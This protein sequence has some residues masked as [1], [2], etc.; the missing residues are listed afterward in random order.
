MVVKEMNLWTVVVDKRDGSS[1]IEHEIA[2]EGD[3]LYTLDN[4]LV[5][6]H[7]HGNV[8]KAEI[9][10]SIRVVIDEP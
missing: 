8:V 7:I 10:G 4:A 3:T 6:A 9:T 1:Q 2:I 5:A